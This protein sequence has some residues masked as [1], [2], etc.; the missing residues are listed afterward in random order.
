VVWEEREQQEIMQGSQPYI[1]IWEGHAMVVR[2][3]DAV[4]VCRMEEATNWRELEE[5]ARASI[6][7]NE[8]Q[9][10]GVFYPCPP[11][12]AEKAHFL[13]DMDEWITISEAHRVAGV[14]RE[15]MY[16]AIDQGT[17][18]ARLDENIAGVPDKHRV[19]RTRVMQ[20][21]PH[22]KTAPN[23]CGKVRNASNASNVRKGKAPT[24]E[25]VRKERFWEKV[26]KRTRKE[27]WPWRGGRTGRGYGTFW[28]DGMAR[29]AHKVAYELSKGEVPEGKYVHHICDNILCMNPAHLALTDSKC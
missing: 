22:E 18:T 14:T 28:A 19:R 2:M 4:N 6:K 5:E 13:R 3:F 21:W 25:T 24:S 12:L 20:L 11:E 8:A 17:L 27:C 26:E 9:M 10:G 7:L 1:E 16:E 29:A 23:W 15:E